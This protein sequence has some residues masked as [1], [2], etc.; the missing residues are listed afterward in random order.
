MKS[1]KKALGVLKSSFFLP[2][3]M[4][5]FKTYTKP[6]LNLYSWSWWW[7]AQKIVIRVIFRVIILE[8]ITAVVVFS[9]ETLWK[10]FQKP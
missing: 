5:K 6:I 7:R 3:I 10:K 2:D 9:Q 4:G 1:K 8:G